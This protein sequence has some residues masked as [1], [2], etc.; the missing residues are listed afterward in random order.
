MH[1]DA[2]SQAF[3]F[4]N[5]IL[6]MRYLMSKTKRY[7]VAFLL[8]CQLRKYFFRQY[9]IELRLQQNK[10]HGRKKYS[11]H[12]VVRSTSLWISKWLHLFIKFPLS[13]ARS[14]KQTEQI[15]IDWIAETN[16]LYAKIEQL[17]ALWLKLKH[18]VSIHKL[19]YT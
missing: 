7:A 9:S 5:I 11:T 10:S 1:D 14:E 15:A 4:R 2:K 17:C 3:F 18:A 13:L 12:V 16:S 8:E 6:N 19:F